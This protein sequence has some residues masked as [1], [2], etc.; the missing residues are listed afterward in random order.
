MTK[1]LAGPCSVTSCT[2]LEP[3]ARSGMVAEALRQVLRLAHG[4]GAWSCTNRSTIVP[5]AQKLTC[6]MAA[7]EALPARGRLPLTLMLKSHL[8]SSSCTDT[9]AAST[10]SVALCSVPCELAP[11]RAFVLRASVS[12]ATPALHAEAGIGS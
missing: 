12:P 6:G 5:T 11:M 3:S 4:M 2:V 1:R 8:R 9:W 7:E 10:N